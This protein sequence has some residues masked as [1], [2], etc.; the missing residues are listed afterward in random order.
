MKENKLRYGTCG[1]GR[2]YHLVTDPRPDWPMSVCF[3][4]MDETHNSP[5][6]YYGLTE[7][8]NC[9]AELERREKRRERVG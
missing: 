9:R 6:A 3:M 2:R 4:A 5:D 1:K 8:K 7:C